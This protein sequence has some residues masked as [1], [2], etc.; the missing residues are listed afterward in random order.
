[1]IRS[2]IQSYPAPAGFSTGLLFGMGLI[3]LIEDGFCWP[4]LLISLTVVALFWAGKEERA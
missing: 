3:C 1:M 2:L 4:L